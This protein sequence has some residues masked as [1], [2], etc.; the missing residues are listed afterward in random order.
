MAVFT[1]TNVGIVVDTFT[2]T[3]YCNKID[4]PAVSVD[5]KDF[6]SFGSGGWKYMQ[7][8][9]VSHTF[10]LEGFQNF[11]SNTVDANIGLGNIVANASDT[12]SIWPT[13]GLNVGD[14]A[15]FGQGFEA[16]VKPLTGAVGD[17]AVVNANWTGTGKLIE[18]VVVHPTAARTATGNGTVQALTGP[19]STQSLYAAFHVLAVSGTGTIT[20]KIQSA[21]LVGFGSPTDRITSTAFAAVG[22]E[23]DSVAG[24]ITDGFYRVT[25]TISGFTSVTFAASIGVL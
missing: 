12:Y 15:Y 22:S 10:A 23:L 2:A 16:Q 11:A 20:F 25:W 3:G 24:A 7:P 21:T 18:G 14:P 17:A 19:T 1:L 13:G 4:G 6:T 9:L 5:M 8:G